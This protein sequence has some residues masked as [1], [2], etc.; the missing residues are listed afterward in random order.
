V[1][2]DSDLMILNLKNFNIT[3]KAKENGNITIEF[4]LYY[5]KLQDLR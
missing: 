3:A 4:S 5:I 2:K 1:E